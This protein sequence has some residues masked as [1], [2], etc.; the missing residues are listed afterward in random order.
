MSHFRIVE[1]PLGEIF[2]PAV[3]EANLPVGKKLVNRVVIDPS[4][5]VLHELVL[6]F[7]AQFLPIS[8]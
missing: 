6:F 1:S 3:S 2:N 7:K 8:I 5:A 4:L